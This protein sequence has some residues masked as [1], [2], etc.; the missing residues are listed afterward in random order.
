MNIHKKIL[1]SFLLIS[2]LSLSIVTV[3][4][5][6]SSKSILSN[7]ILGHLKSVALTKKKQLSQ[8][9][10]FQYEQLALF[11]SRLLIKLILDRS[12]RG[13]PE[14]QDLKKS[15]KIMKDTK[16]NMSVYSKV[17][18]INLKGIVVASS[19]T[20]DIARNISD[21]EIFKKS[22]EKIV[23]DYFKRDNN[24]KIY[25]YLACP[26]KLN[27]QIVGSV[28]IQSK[29][30]EFHD[31]VF[32]ELGLGKTGEIVLAK[33]DL[34]GN[35]VILAPL[36]KER[37]A[38]LKKVISK[39]R[40]ELPIIQALLKKEKV[41]T[42]LKDYQEE[43]ILSASQYIGKTRYNELDWGL[44]VK[45]NQSEAFKPIS[46]LR[47]GSVILIIISIIMILILSYYLARNFSHPIIQLTQAS[48]DILDGKKQ[49]I[50]QLESH[51]EIRDLV[52]TFNKMTAKL[53]LSNKLL[54]E[55]IKEITFGNV[56]Q[57]ATED[58]MYQILHELDDI[59]FALDEHAIV[60]VTDEKG[61]I[62]YVND[63]FCEISKYSRQEL[64]GQDHG[65]L[66]S[67]YHSKEFFKELWETIQKGR[68]WKGEIL[69]R[70]KDGSM[71]WVKSTITPFLDDDNNPY[72]YVAIR[73]DITEQKKLENKLSLL[74]DEQK[75]LSEK[76][77][78][79]KDLAEESNRLKTEF[80]N[81]ISHE[82]KTPLNGI[83]G[84]T[85]LTLQEKLTKEQ[86]EN[87]YMIKESSYLLLSLFQNLF[88]LSEVETGRIRLTKSK[89]NIYEMIQ[90]VNK[91]FIPLADKKNLEIKLKLSDNLPK[92]LLCSGELIE[93]VLLNLVDN[94]IK[95][96]E[97]SQIVIEV[98]ELE[99]FTEE[100]DQADIRLQ[101]MVEDQ[102]IG[103]ADDLKLVIF[104][105]FRQVD[106]SATRKYGGTGVG[107]TTSLKLVELLGGKMWF[108]SEIDGG[109]RFYFTVEGRKIVDPI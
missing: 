33:R 19:A 46:D 71:Y 40:T 59:K 67:G 81:N 14:K 38:T 15:N 1:L 82:I 75:E 9:M 102:G 77:K 80:L 48:K 22:Q 31:Q 21:Q 105:L 49:E 41:Y 57:K 76:L 94:A 2:L 98:N 24:G 34:Q 45:V 20:R 53:T 51:D 95:F 91:L 106:G 36:K 28:I 12:N 72:Q 13:V 68:V 83:I 85:E 66:N 7:H 92:R 109:S 99:I 11:K 23:T 69:N 62:T 64:L 89:I 52:E 43:A 73:T 63:K 70:A 86:C 101:F 60:A 84:F 18:L 104:E 107:L 37:D 93:R 103:I 25:H 16:A 88:Y 55:K 42:D 56:K 97:N 100:K 96:S 26:L 108:E 30:K 5:Y 4:H 6:Y 79:A 90:Y 87:L 32:G 8:Y 58:K 27:N 3:F 10:D 78:L 35:A 65:L 74:L 54:E 47:Q 50:I 61:Q 39:D 17:S 29:I 44:V